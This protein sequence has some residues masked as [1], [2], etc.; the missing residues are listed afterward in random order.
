MIVARIEGGLGNQL[1]QYAF[2]TQLAKINDTELVLDL[3]CYASHPQHGYMLDRFSITARELSPQERKRIPTRYQSDRRSVFPLISLGRKELRRLRERPFG[4]AEKY[5]SAPD[6]SFL[7]GY[8]QSERYFPSVESSL[9]PQFRPCGPMSLESAR[10]RDKMLSA[11]S[12]AIHI[13]RGDYITD[14]PMAIRNLS[15]S[16]YRECVLS[17]LEK[18]PDSEVYVFSND[19]PWCQ[20]NL[21]LTCPVH[22]VEHTDNATA[23]EDLWLMTAA[24]SMVIANST[25]SWW[26]AY[27]GEREDRTIYAPKSWYH[28]NT[29]DDRFINCDHWIHIGDPAI[30]RQAA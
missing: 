10:L 22:F 14:K 2:G 6:D 15:L 19:I 1:F 13:R 23:H 20:D 28:A 18:R 8:W 17:Q 30:E 5:L 21:K 29:L 7:V 3:S 4:F 9:R 25:F 12:I 11:S 26:G 27:L 24:D 16:Y